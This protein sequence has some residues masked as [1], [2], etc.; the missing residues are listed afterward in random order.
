MSKCNLK[1]KIET[2]IRK[3]FHLSQK[4][5]D[6]QKRLGNNEYYIDLRSSSVYS[7]LDTLCEII[8]VDCCHYYQ[9]ITGIESDCNP[10]T[11]EEAMRVLYG[12]RTRAGIHTNA[13]KWKEIQRLIRDFPELPCELIH[14]DELKQFEPYE[15][16]AYFY[17]LT[18]NWFKELKKA[19]EE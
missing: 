15:E 4:T 6:L 8:D 13:S 17:G 5:C 14:T 18:K 11:K 1:W 7:A 19:M 12:E 9:L 16:Y 3:Y 10:D 2:A